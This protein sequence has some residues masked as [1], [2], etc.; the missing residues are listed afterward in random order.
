MKNL[1]LNIT[2]PKCGTTSLYFGLT[3]SAEI[4]ES[5]LKEPRFFAGSAQFEEADMPNAMRTAGKYSNGFGWHETLF[6]NEKQE[7]YRIDFTTYYAVIP[8]T[9]KLVHKHYPDAKLIF[10][11][12]DPVDRFVSHYYQYVKVGMSIPSIED[13]IQGQGQISRLM[14]DFADYRST[15]NR[16]AKIFG[17]K[18]ILLLDFQDLARNPS[19][20]SEKCNAFLGLSDIDYR[21]SVREKNVAGQPRFATLQRAIFSNTV[22][23]FSRSI[24]PALKTKLLTARK[25][26]ILANVKA[27]KYPKLSDSLRDY[28]AERLQDQIE[29]YEQID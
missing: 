13:V 3:A 29:F 12:R 5:T 19:T 2:P 21:P 20:I 16:F 1:I 23:S 11:L 14:Y 15:Y 4:A 10:I 9:P 6:Q 27:A 8:D 7:R 18:A 25:K 24:S 28:L 26:V 17:T 22:R